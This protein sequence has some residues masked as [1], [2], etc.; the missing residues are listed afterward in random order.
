M[1]ISRIKLVL[2]VVIGF[3]IW[4][5][6]CK[7][8]EEKAEQTTMEEKPSVTRVS[9]VTLHGVIV[10]V[11]HENKTFTLKDKDGDVQKMT[12]GKCYFL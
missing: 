7:Q 9:E 5:I 4:M 3:T 11:D 6:S 2:L 12:V 8:G 1:I 10:A